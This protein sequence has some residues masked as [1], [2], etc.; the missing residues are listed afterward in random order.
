MKRRSIHS[1]AIAAAL[2]LVVPLPAF[3]QEDALPAGFTSEPLVKTTVT[4]DDEPIVYPT[5]KPEII[6]VIGTLEKDGR[7]ALHEHPVPVYVYVMEG[8]IELKSEGGEPH[9]YKA[10]EAFIEA[11]DRKHQAF[12]VADGPSKLL[13][14][15]VGEEGKPTTVAASQ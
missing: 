8:E 1:I 2:G 7:T 12:N 14:V 5:G 10:G 9:R 4:R 13:V 6:S 15:F 3:A 11:Q